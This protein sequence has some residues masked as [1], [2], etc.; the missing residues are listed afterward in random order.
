M[1]TLALGTTKPSHTGGKT[2]REWSSKLT[3][4][5]DWIIISHIIGRLNHYQPHHPKFGSLSAPHPQRTTR[6]YTNAPDGIWT[7]I[8]SVRVPPYWYYLKLIK[9][10]QNSELFFKYCCLNTS[11]KWRSV[12]LFAFVQRFLFLSYYRAMGQ[13]LSVS[14]AGQATTAAA[15]PDTLRV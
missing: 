7:H 13:H 8:L 5:E 6:L 12:N 1:S 11:I 14:I 10:E 2:A 4:S 9:V 3:S 15:R